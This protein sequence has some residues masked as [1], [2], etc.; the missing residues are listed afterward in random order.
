[1]RIS[2]SMFGRLISVRLS[3]P[4]CWSTLGCTARPDISGFR[5]ES[6]ST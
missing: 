1:M 6:V 4:I 3:M 5:I 2:F